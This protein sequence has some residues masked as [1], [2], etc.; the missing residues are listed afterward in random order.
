MT[1]LKNSIYFT[2]LVEKLI[3]EKEILPPEQKQYIY[4]TILNMPYDV[5]QPV[6]LQEQKYVNL[7]FHSDGQ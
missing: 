2:V 3:V 5:P 4:T 1:F 6:T 7:C